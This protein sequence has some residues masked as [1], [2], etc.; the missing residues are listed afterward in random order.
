MAEYAAQPRAVT[1]PWVST[2]RLV[3]HPMDDELHRA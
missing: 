3:E 2:T 1:V